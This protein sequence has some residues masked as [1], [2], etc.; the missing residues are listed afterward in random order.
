MSAVDLGDCVSSGIAWTID[1]AGGL[2]TE[3]V[4]IIYFEDGLLVGIVPT[5]DFCGDRL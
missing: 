3:S 5:T 4:R 1:F 2:Y